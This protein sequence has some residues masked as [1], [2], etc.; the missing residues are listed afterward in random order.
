MLLNCAHTHTRSLSAAEN[1][2]HQTGDKHK[3]FRIQHKSGPCGARLQTETEDTLSHPSAAAVK[4]QEQ[5][6]KRTPSLHVSRY[7]TVLER[8]LS[9]FHPPLSPLLFLLSHVCLE[10]TQCAAFSKKKFSTWSCSTLYCVKSRFGPLWRFY[11]SGSQ[12]ERT[13]DENF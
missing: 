7:F 2:G 10:I 4:L 13:W 11:N 6:A 9:F 12:S 5:L 1:A 3:A 8:L